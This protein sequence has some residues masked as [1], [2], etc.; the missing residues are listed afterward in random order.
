M[1]RRGQLHGERF[2]R[3]V[4]D[5]DDPFTPDFDFGFDY[6][7]GHGFVDALEAVGVIYRKERVDTQ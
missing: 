5:M 3:F 4:S 1:G 7:T 2:G 6:A